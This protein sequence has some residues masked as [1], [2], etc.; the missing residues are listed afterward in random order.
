[1]SWS[2]GDVA[3]L[4]GVTVRALHHYDDIGLLSPSG[5]TASGH[6][7]YD[8]ADLQ[9]LQQL[10]FYRELGF[11]LDQVAALLDEPDGDPFERLARQHALLEER[12]ARLQGMADAVARTIQARRAGIT[13]TPEEMFE[14]FGDFDPTRYA[15]EAE[16]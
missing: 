14:V 15:D 1:M 11:P 5:H 9:R 16:A 7:R 10:M 4:A 12:A 3:R 8:E 6:R 13:M 2:V